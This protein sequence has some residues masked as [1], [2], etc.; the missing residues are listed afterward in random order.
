[1]GTK[2]IWL[3]HFFSEFEIRRWTVRGASRTGI[4][5]AFVRRSQLR[6]AISALLSSISSSFPAPSRTNKGNKAVV[7]FVAFCYF[8]V[9]RWAFGVCF[10][11]H[12]TL[13]YQPSTFLI[14]FVS[15]E[16]D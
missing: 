11:N 16:M 8:L 1:M 15:S 7:N 10:F 14:L 2:G 4:G 9:G 6:T 13:N 3:D 5:L 12:S